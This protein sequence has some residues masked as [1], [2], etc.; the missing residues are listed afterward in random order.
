[1]T[2]TV[3]SYNG[4]SLSSLLDQV[5][6]PYRV[7]TDEDLQS[8]GN[9]VTDQQVVCTVSKVYPNKQKFDYICLSPFRPQCSLVSAAEFGKMKSDA[10]A[11]RQ[12]SATVKGEMGTCEQFGFCQ[13]PALIAQKIGISELDVIRLIK[14]LRPAMSQYCGTTGCE[15]VML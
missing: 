9:S 15:C 11:V 12:A 4:N 1:M 5:H 6:A 10:N 7:L 2:H 3:S 8:F 14:P 13:C